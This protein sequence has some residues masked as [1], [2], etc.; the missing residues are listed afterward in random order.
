MLHANSLQNHGFRA[1]LD[2]RRGPDSGRR[3]GCR[4]TAPSAL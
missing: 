2:R 1:R 3:R 4:H